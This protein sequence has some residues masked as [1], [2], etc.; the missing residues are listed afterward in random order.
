MHYRKRIDITYT[1]HGQAVNHFSETK[2]S[3]LDSWW[4]LLGKQNILKRSN[5]PVFIHNI[6]MT[7]L[8]LQISVCYPFGMNV[9]D[10]KVSK[11]RWRCRIGDVMITHS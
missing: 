5:E 4:I 2:I 3:H 1:K 8:G 10:I 9:L 7:D 6:Q 11:L